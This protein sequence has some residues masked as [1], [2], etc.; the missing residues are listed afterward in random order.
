M[1]GR[2]VLAVSAADNKIEN[3]I[4]RFVGIY[5]IS[6]YISFRGIS[7]QNSVWS[8]FVTSLNEALQLY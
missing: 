3:K 8:T 2:R 4:C 7:N 5:Y 1:V 6:T